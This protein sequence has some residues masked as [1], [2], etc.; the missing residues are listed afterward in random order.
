MY[1]KK[2][3]LIQQEAGFGDIFFCQGISEYFSKEYDIIWPVAKQILETTKYLKTNSNIKFVSNDSEYEYNYI[4]KELYESKKKLKLV[5]NNNSE[6]I[7]FLPL[8]YSSHMI[9][10][11]Y[12]K[13]MQAK[14]KICDLDYKNWKQSFNFNRN[15]EKENKLFYDVL[16]LKDNEDYCLVNEQ[17]VTQPDIHKKNLSKFYSTFGDTK[18]IQMQ[19]YDEF[20]LFDWCKVFEHI[21]SIITVDTSL[22]YILEK[23]NLK[24]KTNFLCIT[25]QPHTQEEIQELFDIPWRYIHA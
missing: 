7:I 5:N 23:L 10:P 20:T 6:E 17:Y 1:N 21:N 13:V 9:E 14:Y 2:T 25:R 3:C 19:L 12:K 15:I 16:G 11:Y 4:F 8:G 18:F 24:N 22:M